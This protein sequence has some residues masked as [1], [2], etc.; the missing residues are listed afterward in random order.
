[1]PLALVKLLKAGSGVAS[2]SERRLNK[3]GSGRGKRRPSDRRQ[4]SARQL[5][6]VSTPRRSSTTCA[7]ARV[8]LS[9]F[10]QPNA[11][12]RVMGANKAAWR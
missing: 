10:N 8:G 2:I 5:V 12:P 7:A 6:I 4:G 1:M 3:P 9:Q 11:G